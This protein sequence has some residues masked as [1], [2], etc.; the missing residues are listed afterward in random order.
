MTSQLSA[1][2]VRAARRLRF[3]PWRR[4]LQLAWQAGVALGLASLCLLIL[5]WLLAAAWRL[6]G[7]PGRDEAS[8]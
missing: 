2:L 4:G 1:F 7:G 8:P 6:L 5:A 3:M